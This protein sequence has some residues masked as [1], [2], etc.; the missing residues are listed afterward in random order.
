MLN[1][2]LEYRR[3]ILFLR[4]DG[5][6]TKSNAFILKD[7]LKSIIEK[8]GIKYLLI[9]F[10]KLYRIDDY[11]IDTIIEGYNNYIKN[12]GKLMICG[13]DYIR[14]K[15]DKSDLSKYALRTNDEISAC[16]LINI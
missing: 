14:L 4:L 16:N 13:D 6:L 11:G 3:G 2:D 15:I 12:N 8:A 9:N 1:I 5:A 10:E 7:A